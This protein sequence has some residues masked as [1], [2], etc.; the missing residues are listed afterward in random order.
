M[1]LFEQHILSASIDDATDNVIKLLMVA[2]AI[3][4]ELDYISELMCSGR[5][6][7]AILAD[8]EQ[9]SLKLLARLDDY[10]Q[11]IRLGE[12]YCGM[13]RRKESEASLRNQSDEMELVWERSVNK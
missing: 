10:K 6:G 7:D 13:K 11:A 3:R 2:D 12:T 9:N 1:D 5:M 8:L 4:K